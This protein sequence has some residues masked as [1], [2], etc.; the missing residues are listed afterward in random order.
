MLTGDT[1]TIRMNRL[2]L[3]GEICHQL[4]TNPPPLPVPVNRQSP[5]CPTD[6]VSLHLD[7]GIDAELFIYN[8]L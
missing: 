2:P 5:I 3:E 1:A 4:E 7:T 6:M 8:Y